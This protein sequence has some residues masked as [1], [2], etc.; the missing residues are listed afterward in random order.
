MENFNAEEKYI[1]FSKN[2]PGY[3]QYQQNM[4]LTVVQ[5]IV[6]SGYDLKKTEKYNF[7][8][9][10]TVLDLATMRNNFPV[11]IFQYLVTECLKIDMKVNQFAIAKAV[12]LN[13]DLEFIRTMK[14]NSEYIQDKNLIFEF[15]RMS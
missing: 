7:K 1:I 15:F 14:K 6:E 8:Y 11:E 3:I 2:L 9:F 5:A 10:F 13:C 4:K 12:K